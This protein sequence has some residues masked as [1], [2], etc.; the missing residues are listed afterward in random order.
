MNLHKNFVNYPKEFFVC[1]LFS[2]CGSSTWRTDTLE[3]KEKN[4]RL[5]RDMLKIRDD[6]GEKYN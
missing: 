1:F 3:K 6:F 4:S 5:P 2:F